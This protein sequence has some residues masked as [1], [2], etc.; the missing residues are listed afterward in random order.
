MVEYKKS[1]VLR[2]S[3]WHSLRD[4]IVK[5]SRC[6]FCGS[7]V[8]LEVHHIKPV[9]L[10]PELELDRSNLMV[11]CD[12]EG[13]ASCHWLFGHLCNYESYNPAVLDD[14]AVFAEKVRCRL[15]ERK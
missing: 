1:P 14:A 10:Y 6:A 11:L 13:K 12:A 7:K 3:S 5:N 9:H 15:T 2:S 4:S 8:N